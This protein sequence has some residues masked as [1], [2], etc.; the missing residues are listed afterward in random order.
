MGVQSEARIDFGDGTVKKRK[1]LILRADPSFTT[2]LRYFQ[3]SL[4]VTSKK[5][6]IYAFTHVFR[7]PQI[8]TV[9]VRAWNRFEEVFNTEYEIQVIAARRCFLEFAFHN[10]PTEKENAFRLF[11]ESTIYILSA[12]WSNCMQTE[13]EYQWEIHKVKTFE[14]TPTS[15]NL[16]QISDY[17][18]DM[19]DSYLYIPPYCLDYGN[20]TVG[21]TITM[22]K[23]LKGVKRKR[24]T[25]FTILRK[26]MIAH[27]QGGKK[28]WSSTESLFY[29][30]ASLSYDP[31]YSRRKQPVV[32]FS[33][34]C[35]PVSEFCKGYALLNETGPV[36]VVPSHGLDEQKYIFQ[37]WVSHGTNISVTEYTGTAIQ[38]VHASHTPV[39]FYSI[40]CIQNCIGG[41]ANFLHVIALRGICISSPHEQDQ[42]K[43]FWTVYPNPQADQGKGM[44]LDNTEF[45]KDNYYIVMYEQ[46]LETGGTFKIV[47]SGYNTGTNRLSTE[48]ASYAEFYIDTY[49]TSDLGQCS[50]YP[51]KGYSMITVF[52]ITCFETNLNETTRFEVIQFPNPVD[53][54]TSGILVGYDRTGVIQNV[55]LG[56]GLRKYDYITTL[57]ITQ[58]YHTGIY[59][60]L[61]TN[62][63]V[64]PLIYYLKRPDEVM[65]RLVHVGTG[66]SS[67]LYFLL[68]GGNHFELVQQI[69]SATYTLENFLTSEDSLRMDRK[70]TDE[71]IEHIRNNFI[72]YLRNVPIGD[73]Y[74][75]KHL[76]SALL[77]VINIPFR[78]MRWD[79]TIVSGVNILKKII[80]NLEDRFKMYNEY[81]LQDDM[82]DL[83]IIFL[84]IASS[85]LKTP[86]TDHFIMEETNTTS[87]TS[88]DYLHLNETLEVIERYMQLYMAYKVP[89]ERTSLITS[90][91]LAVFMKKASPE[92]LTVKS[93]A[94]AGR[95]AIGLTFDNTMYDKNAYFNFKA[96][97]MD[98]Y[99]PSS[100]T[101]GYSF[102]FVKINLT[103]IVDGSPVEAD[104]EIDMRP[105]N[106]LKME[107]I[108]GYLPVRLFW[109][110]EE[111]HIQVHR[112]IVPKGGKLL[113]NFLPIEGNYKLQ[114]VV[115][116]DRRP[117]LADF[118]YNGIDIPQKVVQRT[119]DQGLS[120]F[121]DDE[122][123]ETNEFYFLGILPHK[124]T[125]KELM[126]DIEEPILPDAFHYDDDG[127]EDDE[128]NKKEYIDYKSLPL[129]QYITYEQNSSDTPDYNNRTLPYSFSAHSVRC[130]A[131][132]KSENDQK[133]YCKV[134][135][136]TT[137]SRVTCE[138]IGH[139]PVTV[140]FERVAVQYQR[141]ALFNYKVFY[142]DNPLI[143]FLVIFTSILFIGLLN[144][145][146]GED[147][148]D[149]KRRT[150]CFLMD[151]YPQ[152]EYCYLVIVQTGRINKAETTSNVTI[153][154]EGTQATSLPHVLKDW[155]RD[156]FN[157][158]SQEWFVLKTTKSLGDIYA[159][160]IWTDYSG[161]RPSWYCNK[162]IIQ[163]IQEQQVWFFIVEKWFDPI[164]GDGT[165]S[166]TIYRAADEEIF[167]IGYQLK[168]NIAREFDSGMH[169]WL[170]IFYKHPYSNYTR[171]QRVAVAYTHMVIIMLILILQNELP[172]ADLPIYQI[173]PNGAF[174][175][176]N[177]N[178]AVAIR[179]VFF[180]L[181]FHCLL[182]WLFRC[183]KP[184]S[185]WSESRLDRNLS[186]FN[187]GS[188][189]SI[190]YI[191]V[192]VKSPVPQSSIQVTRRPKPI[193]KKVSFYSDFYEPEGDRKLRSKLS[194]EKLEEKA[195]KDKVVPLRSPTSKI[196]TEGESSMLPEVSSSQ[197]YGQ[198]VVTQSYCLPPGWLYVAWIILIL[199]IIP[200]VYCVVFF[201]ISYGWIFS[202]HYI[203]SFFLAI[204]FSVVLIEPIKLLVVSAYLFLYNRREFSIEDRS[205]LVTALNHEFVVPSNLQNQITE[206]INKLRRNPMYMPL[207][208]EQ[209]SKT[210]RNRVVTFL[211]RVIIADLMLLILFVLLLF[212]MIYNIFDKHGYLHYKNV[213]VLFE[214]VEA[215]RKNTIS[216]VYIQED[217]V[218]YLEN[219][220]IENLHRVG[221]EDTQQSKPVR[222]EVNYL[223]GVIRL[224]QV[225]KSPYACQLESARVQ[226]WAARCDEHYDNENYTEGWKR[227]DAKESR[228]SYDNRKEAWRYK[229]LEDHFRDSILHYNESKYPFGYYTALLGRTKQ[230]S[231]EKLKYLSGNKWFDHLTKV[232]S[233]DFVLFNP[234]VH[235]LTLVTLMAERMDQGVYYIH[236]TI[237]KIKMH[238]EELNAQLY[239]IL[240]LLGVFIWLMVYIHKESKKYSL[241]KPKQIFSKKWNLLK[242]CLLVLGVINIIIYTRKAFFL[243]IY[244]ELIAMAAK[245]SYINFGD[246]SVWDKTLITL[247][248]F[249]LFLISIDLCKILQTFYRVNLAWAAISKSTEAACSFVLFMAILVAAFAWT[250]Y[251]IYGTR[252]YYF[253]TFCTAF[254]TTLG[255]LHRDFNVKDFGNIEGLWCITFI[256][257]VAVV[258]ALLFIFRWLIAA[259]VIHLYSAVKRNARFELY[260]SVLSSYTKKYFDT[261]DSSPN[262]KP[263]KLTA[264]LQK[265]EPRLQAMGYLFVHF[266]QQ[267]RGNKEANHRLYAMN[268]ITAS[269]LRDKYRSRKHYY[270]NLQKYQREEQAKALTRTII[271][272]NSFKNKLE[273]I[274]AKVDILIRHERYRQMGL[275]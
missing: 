258:M 174:K 57:R 68:S 206:K 150:V 250:G 77:K 230:S 160:H 214:E 43:R 118:W 260:Q 15:S 34:T 10:A 78:K 35:R 126:K 137:I 167:S 133:P 2:A 270:E 151:N 184:S 135:E 201:G 128:H 239:L 265:V 46:Q 28:V 107:I 240:F 242:K 142:T 56:P 120:L 109:Q 24:Y 257:Y 171:K 102:P 158:G 115:K 84:D 162:I 113:I 143:I 134:K 264:Y 275:G 8:F 228:L 116:K 122:A 124:D 205:D 188:L 266:C 93:L 53:R 87:G 90:S 70:Y 169:G 210:K 33:W 52:T 179:T 60:F 222:D 156:V 81:I 31:N 221:S 30:D 41:L 62:V 82:D 136:T 181:P 100:D 195:G 88:T 213:K 185:Q 1:Y 226:R 200:S 216:D 92:S 197:V 182:V 274:S 237:E 110:I 71:T 175:W 119:R 194:L 224:R 16:Y 86:G 112:L 9:K 99:I 22:V 45:S 76:A 154:L 204:I 191:S 42:N 238:P 80:Q 75:L 111:K 63:T 138:C 55:T 183:I 69:I 95:I 48:N 235:Y 125:L 259:V 220:V 103:N 104:L 67:P 132:S 168:E 50:V 101:T 145:A 243:N 261:L 153:E 146:A 166:Y 13:F 7:S 199:I 186:R 17:Q 59:N 18:I 198:E 248:G 40:I 249:M 268:V 85:I 19:Q 108:D 61:E 252:S 36:L 11:R 83:G 27:I 208:V 176:E 23:P 165:M 209:V 26:P 114:I 91:R 94:L 217:L 98:N 39:P 173:Y 172:I 89:N 79:A 51:L 189:E 164:S 178:L 29:L 223:I 246:I 273:Y 121:V 192:D 105:G 131:F 163:D 263:L 6:Q 244:H 234:H 231:L 247:I 229:G 106:T 232:V 12:A 193:K 4:N 269:I 65:H 254:F 271:I 245:E 267:K 187:M 236:N 272:T 141:F 5:L 97:I 251:I 14:D 215:S 127:N 123:K 21:L 225:R 161:S 170:S 117:R 203:I 255:F 47:F 212:T 152:C 129:V 149:R 227:I 32:T 49:P 3:P 157:K 64:F 148:K 54:A 74:S 219:T 38:E 233:I 58:I 25:W 211:T 207:T 180:A 73:L 37:V 44:R 140:A 139:N 241:L 262:R 202:L 130:I 256:Y 20:F 72:T 144:W 190:L 96:I 253:H 155:T 66:L 218:Y 147:I 159:L 196:E 177:R